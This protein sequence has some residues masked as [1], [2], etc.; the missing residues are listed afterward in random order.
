MSVLPRVPSSIYD[1]SGNIFRGAPLK[2]SHTTTTCNGFDDPF[3]HY[4]ALDDE[5]G[6]TLTWCEIPIHKLREQLVN[7]NHHNQH[8]ANP[9]RAVRTYLHEMLKATKWH[10][11]CLTRYHT[12]FVDEERLVFVYVAE[13]FSSGSLRTYLQE[14]RRNNNNNNKKK[15]VVMSTTTLCRWLVQIL[16]ALAY[17]HARNEVH[18][19]LS[20]DNIFVNGNR[21]EVK[22]GGLVSRL[23][24]PEYDGKRHV[25]ADDIVAFAKVV[26]DLL[27]DG[28][29]VSSIKDVELRVLV[30]HCLEKGVTAAT[31]TAHDFLRCGIFRSVLPSARGGGGSGTTV[32]HTDTNAVGPSDS[33][34]SLDVTFT[35][36]DSSKSLMSNTTTTPPR[37]LGRDSGSDAAAMLEW[38]KRAPNCLRHTTLELVR[39]H[40]DVAVPYDDACCAREAQSQAVAA[41]P[42][43]DETALMGGKPTNKHNAFI[44]TW[45]RCPVMGYVPPDPVTRTNLMIMLEGT[46]SQAHCVPP[47]VEP[48]PGASVTTTE[49]ASAA[50]PA[51]P[52]P[53]AKVVVVSSPLSVVRRQRA[54]D[55]ERRLLD[56]WEFFSSPSVA[57]SGLLS[58]D[59]QHL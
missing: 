20:L 19:A 8:E 5:S 1:P 56:S 49:T 40:C 31:L 21:G 39:L 26:L 53:A 17:L 29:N 3:T 6:R 32:D 4:Q 52:T 37:A 12:C 45:R 55:S 54:K 13:Q 18:G 36:N 7:S 44:A 41:R 47:A 50:L 10:H 35:K 30:Q 51:T 11:P 33:G 34:S 2:S 42:P 15:H 43:L 9:V 59:H 23:M 16:S 25:L 38:A 57:S 46:D 24:L 58:P 14:R 22:V 27:G 28:T 48:E